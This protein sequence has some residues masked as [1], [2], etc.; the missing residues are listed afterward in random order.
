MTN[1]TFTKRIG[2]L[3]GN[4][5]IR[6]EISI[7]NTLPLVITTND[8][9]DKVTYKTTPKVTTDSDLLDSDPDE[10]NRF[11]FISKN[12]SYINSSSVCLYY[13]TKYKDIIVLPDLSYTK[14][15][16]T[17]FT[18]KVFGHRV[19]SGREVSFKH[20]YNI[21][22]SVED[23]N[24]R[25]LLPETNTNL[26]TETKMVSFPGMQYPDFGPDCD[27]FEEM[28]DDAINLKRYH[29]QLTNL[30]SLGEASKVFKSLDKL[31]IYIII[32]ESARTFKYVYLGNVP[33]DPSTKLYLPLNF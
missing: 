7:T 2:Y 14:L 18:H 29:R 17:V 31:P 15:I 30:I 8:I 25:V 26:N 28:L 9:I 22:L 16:K 13:D 33:I 4:N 12:M 10:K 27:S 19:G 21:V 11:I 32:Q 23:N 6:I 3:K 24:N 20:N 5:K 1:D